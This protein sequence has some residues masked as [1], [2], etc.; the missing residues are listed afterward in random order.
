MKHVYIIIPNFKTEGNKGS[1]TPIEL[2]IIHSNMHRVV[3][4][5]NIIFFLYMLVHGFFDTNRN[6]GETHYLIDLLNFWYL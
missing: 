2:L 6:F 5:Q 4:F 3:Y 1:F